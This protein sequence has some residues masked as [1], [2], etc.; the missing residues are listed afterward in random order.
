[1]INNPTKQPYFYVITNKLNGRYYYGSGV[2]D[3]Y[4]GS[5][6][7]LK[8]AY[9]KY[10]KESFEG[11]ILKLFNTREE[12]FI[13]EGRFLSLYK[14]DIDPVSY[15]VCRNANGGYISDEVYENNSKLMKEYRQTEE[16]SL[17]GLK[18]PRANQ[19][20]YEWYNI[21]TGEYLKATQYEMNC[22]VNGKDWKGSSAFSGV[23]RG[24]NKIYKGWILRSNF[25]LFGTRNKLNAIKKENYSNANKG[26]KRIKIS[27][28][29]KGVKLSEEHKLKISNSQS[30]VPFKK[31]TC[32]YCNK[33]GG[34]PGIKR[35]HFDNCKNKL[36]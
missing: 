13:F 8:R 20:I 17:K 10:G 22:K 15:N 5:G 28:A 9:K 14:L 29:K 23:A 34:S 3:G 25:Y 18:N 16:G 31:I 36:L 35:Y 19:T 21:D 1:M 30:G 4:D 11:K 26:K 6:K 27:V 24:T 7:V 2:I 32:P 33:I 12:A